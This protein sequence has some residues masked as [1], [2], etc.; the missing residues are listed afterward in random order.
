MVKTIKKLITFDYGEVSPKLSER[1][2]TDILDKSA[3]YINNFYPTIF[4]TIK[5]RMGSRQL[6]KLQ[7]P[8]FEVGNP[9]VETH[10]GTNEKQWFDRDTLWE[11]DVIN[12][13]KY[14]FTFSAIG[15]NYIKNFNIVNMWTNPHKKADVS[16]NFVEYVPPNRMKLKN[17]I[18]RETGR[19]YKKGN[20]PF[21]ADWAEGYVPKDWEVLPTFKNWKFT[22]GQLSS[23]EIDNEGLYKDNN[24]IRIV[25]NRFVENDI[26]E[27]WKVES[28]AMGTYSALINDYTI[29]RNIERFVY[30]NVYPDDQANILNVRLNQLRQGETQLNCSYTLYDTGIRPSDIG[31][32]KENQYKDRIIQ[33]H[34]E[35]VDITGEFIVYQGETP[36]QRILYSSSVGQQL[37]FNFEKLRDYSPFEECNV[38]METELITFPKYYKVAGCV[39]NDA[40]SGYNDFNVNFFDL[41]PNDT[42]PDINFIIDDK[43]KIVDYEILNEGEFFVNDVN[44][45]HY[46]FTPDNPPDF[47]IT[48]SIDG[49]LNSVWQENI[50][51]YLDGAQTPT[52]EFIVSNISKSYDINLLQNYKNIRIKIID[53]SYYE[54]KKGYI[55]NKIFLNA[56]GFSVL[57][58]KIKIHPDLYVNE[59]T[60]TDIKNDNTNHFTQLIYDKNEELYYW[61]FDTDPRVFQIQNFT[62]S[63]MRLPDFEIAIFYDA[64]KNSEFIGAFGVGYYRYKWGADGYIK[65]ARIVNQGKNLPP[66]KTYDLIIQNGSLNY[67][68][69]RWTT[70][71]YGVCDSVA[72]LNNG[73]R[74]YDTGWHTQ[75]AYDRTNTR[76][77]EFPNPLQ[78]GGYNNY[79]PFSAFI[80]RTKFTPTIIVDVEFQGK[81]EKDDEWETIDIASL[82]GIDGTGGNINCFHNNNGTDGNV[83]SFNSSVYKTADDT[84]TR[85]GGTSKSF[86]YEDEA[87]LKL[88]KY[89]RIYRTDNRGANQVG[90]EYPNY[91]YGIIDFVSS[92][93][94]DVNITDCTLVP[95]NY[96]EKK[97]IIMITKEY[98]LFFLNG[99]FVG[100][101]FKKDLTTIEKLNEIKYSQF[102][103]VIVFTHEKI[104]PFYL[105]YNF[106]NENFQAPE[107]YELQN[108]PKVNFDNKFIKNISGVQFTF[109]W[110]RQIVTTNIDF[111]NVPSF[112]DNMNPTGQ[113]LNGGN[114]AKFYVEII[115]Y[116]NRQA[117]FNVIV[118]PLNTSATVYQSLQLEVGYEDIVS[119]DRGWPSTCLFYQQR[120]WFNGSPNKS[121]FLFSSR[122]GEFNNFKNYS[123]SSNDS[124][125]QEILTSQKVSIVNLHGNKGLQIFCDSCEFFCD[126]NYLTPNNFFVRKVSDIGITKDLNVVDFVDNILFIDKNKTAIN[127]FNFINQ[128]ALPS[129]KSQNISI[130]NQNMIKTPKKLQV[131]FNN[132][133]GEG[134]FIYILNSDGE[135]IIANLLLD[136]G[137]KAF[138]RI[139]FTNGEVKDIILINN[140]IYFIIM[141]N[142]TLFIETF[143]EQLFTDLTTEVACSDEKGQFRIYGLEN[144][145]GKNV[146]LYKYD[147]SW[148]METYIEEPFLFI[149]KSDLDEGVDLEG[150]LFIGI[151][152]YGELELNNITIEGMTKNIKKRVAQITIEATDESMAN[153]VINEGEHIKKTTTNQYKRISLTGYK[154]ENN[155]KIRTLLGRCEIKSILEVINY[156]TGIF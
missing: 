89:F 43:G 49:Y 101:V 124:I 137:I 22:S 106:E 55:N 115:D 16:L 35:S 67:G 148:Y 109:D 120:L 72:I 40:G 61:E 9:I 75:W 53:C 93:L 138:T 46:E 103:N 38:T 47:T 73:F 119:K 12:D 110:S 29:Y 112:F 142:E 3:K 88:Y 34:I 24:S 17:I 20:I 15:N 62:L 111:F 77:N 85:A 25:Y 132:L 104:A 147:L 32:P 82:N 54:N 27:L 28:V 91:I 6:G 94:S 127:L 154:N 125:Q 80:D 118:P 81:K 58:Y 36:E 4:G 140:K 74:H 69:I 78:G 42:A 51:F 31:D 130:L 129:Y 153:L 96:R 143:E 60:I 128:Q 13:A 99:Q 44:N 83:I 21:Y 33:T 5:T 156:G 64:W 90:S 134:N 149:N 41:G 37:S 65:G 26:E 11:S 10:I 50:P 30:S 135:I 56:F 23:V 126:D 19:Q 59:N 105:K 39:I 155:V 97:Y 152:Y 122:L 151:A 141:R 114:L 52:T 113:R 14:C 121:G 7:Q 68:A 150:S 98:I 76:N 136:D 144:Y 86:F 133:N 117:S 8:G 87:N 48:F 79:A 146:I 1:T 92:D 45:I 131:D 63:K 108:L 123:N 18:I 2:D 71:S 139:K 57:D 95:F 84:W 102:N 116:E 107:D 66:N 100:N 70:N 145:V